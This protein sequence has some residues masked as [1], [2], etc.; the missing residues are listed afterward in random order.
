MRGGGNEKTKLVSNSFA[1]SNTPRVYM[2]REEVSLGRK[3]A[4]KSGWRIA[5]VRK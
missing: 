1:V 5:D 4:A 3:L 2:S